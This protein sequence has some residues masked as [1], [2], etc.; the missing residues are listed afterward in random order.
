MYSNIHV[1]LGTT[2][3]RAALAGLPCMSTPPTPAPPHA[4]ESAIPLTGRTVRNRL[5]PPPVTSDGG[6][7]FGIHQSWGTESATPS[8]MNLLP[9]AHHSLQSPLGGEYLGDGIPSVPEKLAEKIRKGEFVEMGE[10]LPKF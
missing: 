10:L 5:S 7:G 8:L 1:G 4:Q 6:T 3:N 2:P 9:L